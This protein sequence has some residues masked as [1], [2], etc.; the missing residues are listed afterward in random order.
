MAD[1]QLSNS[2]SWG[3]ALF[4]YIERPGQPLSIASVSVFE[5]AITAQKVRELVESKLPLIPRY[6]QHVVFPPF[7]IGLPTW[8]FAPKFDIRDHIRQVTLRRGTES[9]L[10]ALTSKI[11]STHLDRSKPLWDLT[12]VRGLQD[13]RSAMIARIHHCMADGIA[14][15]GIFNVLMDLSPVPAPVPR[16]KPESIVAPPIRDAGA[17]FLDHLVKSYSSMV[18]GALSL[19]GEA[20]SIAQ[21]MF[22]NS[23]EPL[24][25]LMDAVPE[26][27]SPAE[28][29]PFNVVCHGP[30]KFGWTEISMTDIRTLRQQRGGTVNDVI[31]TV[32]AAALRRYSEL[33]GVKVKG[34]SVR[35]MIPVNVRGD[36]S[37]S[38]L[39]NRI[40]FLPVTLPLDVRDPQK[41]FSYVRER[42]EFLKRVRAAE[43]VGFAGGLFA[44]IPTPIWAAIGPVASQ[45]P[46]SLANI[47]CTNVPGP[48]APLYLLGHKMVSWYP[49]VPIGGE[50]GVNCAILSYN[51]TAYFGFTCDVAAVPDPENLEK[52]VKVSFDELCKTGKLT[53]AET[54]AEAR[55]TERPKR[56]RPSAKIPVA[57]ATKRVRPNGKIPIPAKP[58]RERK[59]STLKV[60]PTA[61]ETKPATSV[62]AVQPEPV[63]LEE[64]AFAAGA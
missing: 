12:I 62:A 50:M 44:T 64:K 24:T 8:E 3:D 20:M 13:N 54:K 33:R 53:E 46:L 35:I 56:T 26:L 25:N 28:R 19:H 32:M 2:F 31:L 34:R 37:V 1:S 30:Q 61:P 23:A 5:G 14:G 17:Q 43:F 22:A 52:F 59:A 63:N 4:L 38:E 39:G 40:Y 42:M 6:R 47:I 48:Q 15:V 41:L 29:L 18:K 10:K 21:Q 9:D 27:A 51:G 55:V 7:N 49:Y 57:I 58:R 16:R 60:K 11:I 45:L 36:D